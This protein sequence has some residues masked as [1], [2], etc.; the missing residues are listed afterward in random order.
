MT[1]RTVGDNSKPIDPKVVS[2]ADLRANDQCDDGGTTLRCALRKGHQGPHD[3]R[4]REIADEIRHRRDPETGRFVPADTTTVIRSDTPAPSMIPEL[5]AELAQA[6]LD[7]QAETWRVQSTIRTAERL[8][9]A[10][11]FGDRIANGG[12][13]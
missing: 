8:V 2:A 5:S 4:A 6:L 3:Y 11:E 13:S 9:S 10:I 1:H 12:G 7:A